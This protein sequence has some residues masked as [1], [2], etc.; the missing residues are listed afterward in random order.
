VRGPPLARGDQVAQARG[1]AQAHARRL[2]VVER[3]R[4]A[5]GAGRARRRRRRRAAV[6][7]ARVLL[8]AVGAH[9]QRQEDTEGGD[10]H[11]G[12]DGERCQL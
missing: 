1:L 4:V 10:V 11:P 7:A 2:G 8:A 3:K 6:V 12:E 9:Q 5:G